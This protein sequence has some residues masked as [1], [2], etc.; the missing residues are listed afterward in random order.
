MA[1]VAQLSMNGKV[2]VGA[3]MRPIKIIAFGD[4]L[5]S[6]LGIA[7]TAAFPARLESALKAKG[8]LVTVVNAGVSGDT[9]TS[10]KARIDW[11]VPPDADAVIVE[12][13]ANDALRGID[14]KITETA[15]DALL[16]RL[17][18]RG[19]PILLVGMKAPPNMGATYEQA[20]NDIF[21]RLAQRHSVLF[22]PFFLDGV[23]ANP[24][25]NQP[26]GIHP[27][28]AGVAVIVGRILPFVERL[29][30]RIRNGNQSM[31][32]GDQAIATAFHCN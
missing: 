28:A 10:G 6:G 2:A 29:I 12:L 13:G 9:A 1:L 18:A 31:A 27:N 4:S 15:L 23:A 24:G 21:P 14:P 25:L 26:D 7:G 8:H 22:Y 20:F 30:S 32:A 16:G 17:K 3:E 5:T 19:L 11:S